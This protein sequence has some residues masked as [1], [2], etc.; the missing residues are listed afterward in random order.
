MKHIIS[1]LICLATIGQLFAQEVE[2]VNQID[3]TSGDHFTDY[4]SV[5]DLAKDKDNNVFVTGTISGIID[6]DPYN[7][8]GELS[9][10]YGSWYSED[11]YVA[12]YDADGNFLWAKH[13]IAEQGLGAGNSLAVDDAGNVYVAG[14]QYDGDLACFLARYTANGTQSYY[15]SMK[16]YTT[17]SQAGLITLDKNGN[18]YFFNRFDGTNI[19]LDPTGSTSLHSA[20]GGYDAYIAKFTASTGNFQWAKSFG[21]TG[22][23]SPYDIETDNTYIYVTGGF[24]NTVDFN[25]DAGTNN[26]TSAGSNDIFIARYECSTGAYDYAYQLGSSEIAAGYNIELDNTHMYIAFQYKGT[27][28]FQVGAGAYNLTSANLGA[29]FSYPLFRMNK[30]NLA[31]DW[32]YNTPFTNGPPSMDLFEDGIIIAHKFTD[33]ADFDPGAGVHTLSN[34]FSSGAALYL[35]Y[36]RVFQ[37]AVVAS[38]PTSSSYYQCVVADNENGFFYGTDFTG[39]VDVDPDGNTQTLTPGAQGDDAFVSHWTV[40]EPVAITTQPSP[41][42]TNICE[43]NS[44]TYS[45]SATG[46]SPIAY[47]WLRN[48][49]PITGATSSSYAASQSGTYFCYVSNACGNEN[50]SSVSLTVDTNV[51]ITSASASESPICENAT[52]QITANGISGTGASLT[53]WTGAG[54]TGS[55]LGSSNPLTVNPG[56]YYARITGTC[57]SPAEASVTVASDPQPTASAGG[58]ETICSNG[59]ATVS[60]ATA[61]NGNI[62][63]T[64]N[65]NGSLSD[66]ATLTPTY[67]ADP[68]DEGSTVTLTMTVTSTNACATQ[69][70][71][72]TYSVIVDP[73]PT[74][75]AGGNETICSNG[76]A[77]VSGAT[78]SNGSIAWTHNGN[79]S[80][81]DATTLT[82][83]YNANPADE[84]S[85]VTLTMTVTSTN[86]CAPQTATATNS[87]IVDPQPTAS[88]GGSETICSNGNATVSG[89]TASNGSIA[90]T[91]NGN[92]SLT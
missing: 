89:A 36:N 58:N 30:N 11:P 80:L 10:Y 68:A 86:S 39:D 12:K 21:G 88:A 42:S 56:T 15:Y 54:G 34:T 32:G 38:E 69:T 1:I 87:V 52:T 45:V 28:D 71:T 50:S 79:G 19:D 82:P 59:N 24:P 9:A 33:G 84:G 31:V 5:L 64:H 57:G 46:T 75:S 61:S 37:W 55:N 65:G 60:G 78:A 73:L 51:G 91:H 40:C 35:D 92:G 74:A 13:I 18:L 62:A 44:Q 2:W 49:T 29:D 4:V 47:Q 76:N 43:G 41:S 16:G 6:F 20:V 81:T 27:V 90:W 23:E 66:A 26:L 8:G 83:T 63:W 70:A 72:A 48:G 67:N 77:T 14:N 85:T 22:Y 25:P 7:P 3:Q 53:W 17:S